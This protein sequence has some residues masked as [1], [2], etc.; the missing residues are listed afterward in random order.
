MTKTVLP[1][2]IERR[3]SVYDIT[4]G[5]TILQNA[6]SWAAKCSDGTPGKAL[7]VSN[8]RVYALYGEQIHADLVR[9]GFL[10]LVHLI[11]DGERF[12][13]IR[14]LE[15]TL[16][17][18][19]KNEF[20]RTDT[21][22]ALGGGVVGDLA[23]FA[24]SIYL[25]G[26]GL[27]QIPTTLLSMIDSSVGGKTAVNSTFG[28]NLTGA[29]YQPNGVLIDVQSLRTLPRRELTAGFCEA[30]KQGAIGGKSLFDQTAAILSDHP[31][32][33]FRRSFS[34]RSFTFELIRLL[35]SH[36]AFK[37]KIVQ[38]DETEST[39]NTSHRS[40]K[41]LNFGHTFAHAL[42]KATDYK[43]LK[44]GEAVGYGIMFAAAL[45]KKLELI[46]Q[47]EVDLLNDVVRRAGTLPAISHI[48]P[49]KVSRAFRHDKK[50]IGDSLQWI[51]LRGIGKPVIVPSSEIPQSA[52]S[53]TL[54]TIIRK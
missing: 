31:I 53:S 24:A 16:K 15:K 51:L 13:N 3:P 40:R 39:R 49:S 26:I 38:N 44:H 30:V 8:E 34:D 6:G 43:Y 12:K 7:I 21:V 9:A 17:T 22:V 48:D 32:T 42:E 19:S 2:R 50:Q 5:S 36:I 46:S 10:V 11:G 29:F 4:V 1:V 23:G 47:D 37:A 25:R 52:I 28:K 41:I 45:S 35:S 33:E 18:L 27:L 20:A 14:T 54:K